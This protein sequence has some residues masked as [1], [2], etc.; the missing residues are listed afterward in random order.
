MKKFLLIAALVMLFFSLDHPLVNEPREAL[1]GSVLNKVGGL[2]KTS[3]DT[4]A[5]RTLA[6]IESE[7][8]LNDSEADY[9]RGSLST[10]DGLAT[11]N[12][13]YCVNGDLNLYFYSQRLKQVCKLVAKERQQESK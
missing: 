2:G 6:R 12:T 1:F 10:N 5:K 8:T 13:R 3:K 11:F 7:M 4:L 9:L